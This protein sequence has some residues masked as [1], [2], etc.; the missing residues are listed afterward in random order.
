[1]NSVLIFWITSLVVSSIYIFILPAMDARKARQKK[2]AASRPA[3][4][5]IGKRSPARAA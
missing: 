5:S 3:A 1:M 4:N 2:S